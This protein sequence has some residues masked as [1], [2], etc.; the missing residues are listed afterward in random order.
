MSSIS[1]AAGT[2]VGR[3]MAEV[4][5]TAMTW[6]A[7]SR[8]SMLLQVLM[9]LLVVLGIYVI[10]LKAMNADKMYIDEKL[11]Q[12][13]PRQVLIV[14]GMVDA[15]FAKKAKYNT[16]IPF[17][18][19][20]V[21]IKPSVNR[22][23]GAQFTYSFWIYVGSPSSVVDRTIFIKGDPAEYTMERTGKD[24]SWLKSNTTSN[25]VRTRA[26]AV[27]CP[28][29]SF[30]AKPME[31]SIWFNRLDDVHTR[32]DVVRV[33]SDQSTMRQ[34]LMSMFSGQ[35]VCVTIVFEDNIPI[36]DFENGIQVRFFVNDVL[37]QTSRFSGALKQN[38]GDLVLFPD[39]QV[40]EQVKISDLEYYNYAVPL[41]IIQ[42]KVAKG[43]TLTSSRSVPGAAAAT[44]NGSGSVGLTNIGYGNAT[45][46]HNTSGAG[47]IL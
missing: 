6:I 35:W 47:G 27:Y 11:D 12:S 15:S 18:P 40:L 29:V 37:Y 16:V 22:K 44:G 21:P 36:T 25:V 43:P 34:N 14:D 45:D 23:G 2:M 9:G 7:N 32:M 5:S 8:L 17:A 33:V 31:F 1:G 41:E 4:S 39:D 28:M 19:Y 38:H 20:Y 46:M 13:R 26:R 30:G 24:A 10:A 3:S 42:K